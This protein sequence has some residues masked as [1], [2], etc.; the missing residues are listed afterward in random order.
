MN[1]FD[2]SWALLDSC[3]TDSC[4]NNRQLLKGL[5]KCKQGEELKLYTNGGEIMFDNYGEFNI[6]PVKIFYNPKAIATVIAIR[7]VLNLEN[8]RIFFIL[9]EQEK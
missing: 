6:L 1:L 3:S 9:K 5:R 7:D 8:T 4:T 2:P